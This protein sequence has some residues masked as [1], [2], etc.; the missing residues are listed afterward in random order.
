MG[1]FPPLVAGMSRRKF[2]PIAYRFFIVNL[3]IFSVLMRILTP[4]QQA[5]LGRTFFRLAQCRQSF[6]G[7][8]ILGVHD[9]SIQQ[10]TRQTPFRFY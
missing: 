6:P 3:I 9:R 8:C 4:A 5:W 1:C 2:I 7:H 10:R